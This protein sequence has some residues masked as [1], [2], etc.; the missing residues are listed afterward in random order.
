MLKKIYIIIFT[1]L[2]FVTDFVHSTSITCEWLPGCPDDSLI[3]GK[4][5][6]KFIAKVISE[7][8]QIVAVIAVFA[9]IFSWVMYLLSSWEEEKANKAKKWIIYSLIGVFISVS[10]WWIIN[11]LNNIKI[12]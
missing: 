8:M 9:L 1:S 2:L 5:W 4:S 12:G 11:L 7:F 10:A 3:D 6:L